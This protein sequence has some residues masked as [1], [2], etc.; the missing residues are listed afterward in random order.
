[1]KIAIKLNQQIRRWQSDT[2]KSENCESVCECGKAKTNGKVNLQ[3][4]EI[5]ERKEYFTAR[6]NEI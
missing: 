5:E 1:M 4:G 2:V 6:N 3:R